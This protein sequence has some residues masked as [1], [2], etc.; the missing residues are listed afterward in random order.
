MRRRNA[1]RRE[2][3]DRP[4]RTPQPNQPVAHC[5]TLACYGC[6]QRTHVERLR[7]PG[8]KSQPDID[9][10]RISEAGHALQALPRGG[11]QVTRQPQ[12]CIVPIAVRHRI[13]QPQ[14]RVEQDDFVAVIVERQRAACQFPAFGQVGDGGVAIL[15]LGIRLTPPLRAESAA[16][17]RDH[18]DLPRGQ[19]VA[20]RQGVH[21]LS[22]TRRFRV[23]ERP[24]RQVCVRRP[25]VGENDVLPLGA[26]I[27][28]LVDRQG[29]R[30]WSHLPQLRQRRRRRDR[31]RRCCRRR[32]GGGL[33]RC[34][35]RR[36][37]RRSRRRIRHTWAAQVAHRPRPGGC[38]RGPRRLHIVALAL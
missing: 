32:H 12:R 14:R 38:R 16:V 8:H 6:G 1:F 5:G 28:D 33:R 13:R 20:V 25:D 37:C 17:A 11:A 3:A 4:Q 34:A 24:A 23:A 19:P 21:A 18:K 10:R 2:I 22:V 36:R 26:Q 7:R 35:R 31:L 27:I 9:G 30:L 15:D 29:R